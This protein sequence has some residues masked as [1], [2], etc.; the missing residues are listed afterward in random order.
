MVPTTAPFAAY[1][2]IVSFVA[3]ITLSVS[4]S[5]CQGFATAGNF[6]G[7]ALDGHETDTRVTLQVSAA[8]DMFAWSAAISALSLLLSLTLQLLLTDNAVTAQLLQTEESIWSNKVKLTIGSGSWLALLLQ[9]GALALIGQGLKIVN[10]GSGLAIQVST[11][12][13]S[14]ICECC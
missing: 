5:A 2:Q 7:A 1:L 14:R 3:T 6:L 10:R 11:K 12:Y 13:D 8:A 4:T 9:V